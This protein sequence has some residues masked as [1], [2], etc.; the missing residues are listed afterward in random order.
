MPHRL[1]N[2]S[3]NVPKYE[4]MRFVETRNHAGDQIGKGLA[5]LVKV[6]RL[7][8]KGHEEVL[9]DRLRRNVFLS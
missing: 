9:G 7:E 5:T 3:S 4:Y 2:P 6:R 8:K 1:I